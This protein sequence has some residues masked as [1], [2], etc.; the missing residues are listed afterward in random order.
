MEDKPGGDLPQLK[1]SAMLS[2]SER[3]GEVRRSIGRKACRL[4]IN[5]RRSATMTSVHPNDEPRGVIDGPDAEHL[6]VLGDWIAA[7]L[8]V[9]TFDLS[10]AAHIARALSHQTGRGVRWEAIPVDG[11]RLAS[12]P[13]LAAAAMPNDAQTVV[14]HFGTLEST[15]FIAPRQWRAH[16]IAAIDALLPT[17]ADGGRIL[18]VGVPPLD[19]IGTM[20]E[21]STREVG[22][23]C[24]ALND[25][26]REVAALYPECLFCEYP[27]GLAAEIWDEQ[28]GDLR[29]THSNAVCGAAIVRTLA[30]AAQSV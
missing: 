13:A 21:L 17:L 24:R 30:R 28:K 9:C 14:L 22:R 25:A 3:I 15:Q 12:V 1:G 7:G 29:Y 18:I 2:V 20:T 16:L 23:E 10:L 5:F 27:D 19:E 26:S 4:E 11:F 8:G 6:V